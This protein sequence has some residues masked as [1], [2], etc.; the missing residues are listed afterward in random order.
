MIDQFKGYKKKVM[1]SNEPY[2]DIENYDLKK[3][4]KQL[5]KLI[6]LNVRKKKCQMIFH[7]NKDNYGDKILRL[8]ERRI[9]FIQKNAH[10]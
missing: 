8:R 2:I 6:V 1:T 5:N 4:T 9:Y 10:L 7:I 3:E